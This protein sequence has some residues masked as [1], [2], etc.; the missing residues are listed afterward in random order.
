[1]PG[2]TGPTGANGI[3]FVFQGAWNS[4]QTYATNDVVTRD[5]SVYVAVAVNTG[6]SPLNGGFWSLFAPGG[7][8]GATGGIGPAGPAGIA[9]PQGSQG[10]AGPAGPQGPQGAPG[11]VGPQGVDGV[12]G[13]TGADGAGVISDGN[14]NTIV[15]VGSN[16]PMISG[17]GGGGANTAVG[18]HAI[19]GI[20]TLTGNWN[21]GVGVNASLNLISGNF[22]SA[23]GSEALKFNTIGS[24]N[25]AF[26]VDALYTSIAGNDNTAVGASSLV[27]LNGGSNNTALG[28]YAG[29]NLIS[30][31]NNIYLG[32]KA[33]PSESGAIRIGDAN[34]TKTFISGISGVAT[35][36]PAQ[37][38]MIDANGQLGTASASVSVPFGTLMLRDANGVLLGG[39][40]EAS[41]GLI[42][43][44]SANVSGVFLLPLSATNEVDPVTGY[45][46]LTVN[47][48]AYGQVLY[49]S[50]DCSGQ[51]FLNNDVWSTVS[52]WRTPPAFDGVNFYI[53]SPPIQ[54]SGSASYW[55]G[56]SGCQKFDPPLSGG[57]S[58][59]PAIPLQVNSIGTLPFKISP[60]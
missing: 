25:A 31:S 5:G 46:I 35:G 18:V 55:A 22:N 60:N 28:R 37:M 19:N 2:A 21:T 43:S 15:G 42:V 44:K 56:G 32:N 12:T 3:G 36:Q 47:P 54:V 1:M 29:M 14:F 59:S 23:Y 7:A 33:E 4:T 41:Q 51:P 38:V 26:G 24:A 39:F 30:G 53:P 8:T 48:V 9:G 27:S 6:Q 13:A 50:D 20:G 34:Q 45:P 49:Q 58:L 17:A 57:L 16:L 52:I 10:I 40:S 11:P